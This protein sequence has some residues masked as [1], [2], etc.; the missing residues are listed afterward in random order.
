MIELGVLVLVVLVIPHDKFW[1][2]D[3]ATQSGQ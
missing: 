1:T 2:G 3:S